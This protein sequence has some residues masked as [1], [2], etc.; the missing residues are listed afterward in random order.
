MEMLLL[1]VFLPI[2]W[3][4]VGLLDSSV[5]SLVAHIQTTTD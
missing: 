1:L 2:Y 5:P 3:K 4:V